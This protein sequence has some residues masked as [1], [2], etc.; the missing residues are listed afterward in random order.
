ML[1]PTTLT[2]PSTVP[3]LRVTLLDG[4]QRVERFARTG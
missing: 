1:E 3:P 4:P 2:M